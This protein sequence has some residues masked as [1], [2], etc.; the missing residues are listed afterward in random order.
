MLEM[1]MLGVCVVGDVR[2]WKCRMFHCEIFKIWDVWVVVFGMWDAR[3]LVGCGMLIQKM[4]LSILNL[5]VNNFTFLVVLL[6]E[7]D[8]NGNWKTKYAVTS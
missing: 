1:W 7:L 3:F 5:L 4:S 2:Y 6:K 8:I